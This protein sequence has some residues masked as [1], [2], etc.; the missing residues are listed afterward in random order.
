MIDTLLCEL[1]ASFKISA[2]ADDLLINVGVE[3]RL[4]LDSW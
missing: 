1:S 2:Y 3:T 4:E